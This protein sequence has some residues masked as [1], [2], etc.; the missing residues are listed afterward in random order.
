MHLCRL[1]FQISCI[2]LAKTWNGFSASL[3]EIQSKFCQIE[4][5]IGIDDHIGFQ[6]CK[7]E[8]IH[9]S[10]CCWSWP[11]YPHASRLCYSAVQTVMQTVQLDL[12]SSSQQP[13]AWEWSIG[14]SCL[15]MGIS[16]FW[17]VVEMFSKLIQSCCIT[18]G[19]FAMSLQAFG[20]LFG[21]PVH[22]PVVCTG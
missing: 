2:L 22:A 19:L 9:F 11:E 16:R 20:L 5:K 7:Y 12:P 17:E 1:K 10:V 14:C 13:S 18:K 4:E 8:P 15:H 3:G 6:T 21:G